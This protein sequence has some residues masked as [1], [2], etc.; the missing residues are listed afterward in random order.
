M[1][2]KAKTAPTFDQ[3]CVSFLHTLTRALLLSAGKDVQQPLHAHAQ[4]ILGTLPRGTHYAYCDSTRVFASRILLP[5]FISV[6]ER[7]RQRVTFE[8]R[9]NG[10]D[11]LDL[12][13]CARKVVDPVQSQV[14]E[15]EVERR[16]C[17]RQELLVRYDAATVHFHG[18]FLPRRCPPTTFFLP[19][20]AGVD[21]PEQGLLGYVALRQVLDAPDPALAVQP[22]LRFFRFDAPMYGGGV[23]L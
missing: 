7:G 11:L 1:E 14:A 2:R 8:A 17:E 23:R 21:T 13:Q 10:P 18:P 20:A 12:P 4:K 3:T 5:N 6:T 15:D 16:R 19:G 22:R 9:N